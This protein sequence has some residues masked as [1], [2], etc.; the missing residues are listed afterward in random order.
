MSMLHIQL[1]DDALQLAD[2][3]IAKGRFENISDY[4]AAL[5]RQDHRPSEVDAH[6]EVVRARLRSTEPNEMTDRDFDN[7]R[8]DLERVYYLI[9]EDGIDVL[10]VMHGARDIERWL[11]ERK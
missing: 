1:P 4:I 8:E 10:A 7:I 2:E 5:I 3:E 11:Q 9:V 6:A